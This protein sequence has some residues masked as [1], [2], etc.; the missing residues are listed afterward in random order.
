MLFAIALQALHDFSVGAGR[1]SSGLSAFS[2][3]F[4]F[5][6][7]LFPRVVTV[8]LCP[9]IIVLWLISVITSFSESEGA[10]SFSAASESLKQKYSYP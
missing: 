6:K 5:A 1:I 9:G 2:F 10:A 7:V 3:S 4:S 8:A